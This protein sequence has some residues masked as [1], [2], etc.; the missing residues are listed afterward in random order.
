MIL[1][2]L[3]LLL[4]LGWRRAEQ[5]LPQLGHAVIVAAASAMVGRFGMAPTVDLHH[6]ADLSL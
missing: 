1:L 5:L 6:T 3:S 2:I 4:L